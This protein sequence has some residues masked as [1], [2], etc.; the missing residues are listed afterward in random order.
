MLIKKEFTAF[1]KCK[2]TSQTWRAPAGNVIQTCV[3][4]NIE[5]S[6][7][8]AMTFIASIPPR[9]D[10]EA[11][12]LKKIY[13]GRPFNST[14]CTAI[15][16]KYNGTERNS[17]ATV[18]VSIFYQ[19]SALQSNTNKTGAIRVAP[20]TTPPGT[21]ISFLS[22]T[23]STLHPITP[24]SSSSRP[25]RRNHRCSPLHA[26]DNEDVDPNLVNPP[27]L[28]RTGYGP[29]GGEH[30]HHSNIGKTENVPAKTISEAPSRE[31][32]AMPFIALLS[33]LLA[34]VI[35]FENKKHV[36]LLEAQIAAM[37]PDNSKLLIFGV[38]FIALFALIYLK[39]EDPSKYKVYN[40]N[41]SFSFQ[42]KVEDQRIWQAPPGMLILYS[43]LEPEGLEQKK[44]T[45]NLNKYNAGSFNLADVSGHDGANINSIG[46]LLEKKDKAPVL[47]NCATLLIKY[48][49]HSSWGKANG[50][51]KVSY[52][53][54]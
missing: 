23:P 14:K 2:N 44:C 39:W 52:A 5:E 22:D 49:G 1:G 38:G 31:N 46:A 6:P 11:A 3:I 9:R 54:N 27:P 50:T 17:R 35:G 8:A 53:R 51:V 19:E 18:M 29:I 25:T 24:P 26:V 37:N 30:A 34:V 41:V 15:I 10:G 45:V 21:V 43:D 32:T 4:N 33:A 28:M 42:G 7:G 12:S 40:E 48:K 47:T 20:T 16:A 13:P 36:I